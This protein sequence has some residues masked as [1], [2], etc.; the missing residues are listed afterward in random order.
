MTDNG[1]VTV[2]D[3]DQSPPKRG[4]D[5]RPGEPEGWVAR[6]LWLLGVRRQFLVNKP[7]QLR[8]AMLIGM[9]VLILLVLV[10]V[11]FHALRTNETNTI[12]ASAPSLK[13]VMQDYD[14]NEMLLVILASVVVL[15]GVFVMTIIETHRTA[16]AA[17]NIARQLNRIADGNLDVELRLRKGDNLQEIQAPFNAMVAALRDQATDEVTSLERLAGHVDGFGNLEGAPGVASELRRL[18]EKKRQRLEPQA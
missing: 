7:R 12:V 14:R 3:T 1:S 4:S 18:V 6:Q 17:F 15:G 2:V 13:Q 10:N 9:L 8:T 16:G 11:V 5:L